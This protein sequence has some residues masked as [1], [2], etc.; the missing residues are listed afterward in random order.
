MLLDSLENGINVA[1]ALGVWAMALLGA[2][3][4]WATSLLG[5]RMGQM[6]RAG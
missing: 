2:G 4:L 6:F 1:S 3:L 5:K